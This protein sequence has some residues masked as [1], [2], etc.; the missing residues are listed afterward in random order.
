MLMRTILAIACVFALAACG[1]AGPPV[2]VYS[3]AQRTVV[4]S[5]M[6]DLDL[7]RIEPAT[8]SARRLTDTPGLIETDPC[9]SPARDRLAYATYEEVPTEPGLFQSLLIVRPIGGDDSAKDVGPRA[10][11][12]SEGGIV[13][14]PAW[15]NDGERIAFVER[16]PDGRLMIKLVNA[17]GTGVT[18][19]GYGN[20]PSWRMD[21]RAIYFNASDNPEE[22]F[23][24]LMVRDLASGVVQSLG[25]RGD[26]FTNLQRG[27]SIVYTKPAYSRRNEAVWLIDANNKE[28]RLSDPGKTHRDRDPVHLN[29]TT[30]VAFTRVD[31]KTKKA[32]VYVVDRASDDPVEVPLVQSEAG[33]YTRGGALFDE[34]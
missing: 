22:P 30:L 8:Q 17:D 32:S 20:D 15:S 18:E 9:L 33:A 27:M 26:G 10:V 16:Q 2:L 11:Y 31:V 14:T 34:R 13:F 19:L 25:L 1:S 6:P 24:K 12:A 4:G 23:G 5:G 29:G 3:A 21:D 7:Y 28:T